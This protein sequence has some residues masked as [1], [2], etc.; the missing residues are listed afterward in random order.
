MGVIKTTFIFR[1]NEPIEVAKRCKKL[2]LEGYSFNVALDKAKKEYIIKA[3]K[4]TAK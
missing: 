4:D 2:L 1:N 3:T